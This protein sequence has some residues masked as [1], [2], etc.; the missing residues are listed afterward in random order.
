MSEE[1]PAEVPAEAAVDGAEAP[2][3]RYYFPGRH[4]KYCWK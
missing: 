3:V 4:R 1:K 2:A